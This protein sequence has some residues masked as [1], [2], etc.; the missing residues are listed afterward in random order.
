MY[1]GNDVIVI[2]NNIND[3]SIKA[4]NATIMIN[5]E[6]E[7]ISVGKNCSFIDVV[8]KVGKNSQLI[9][10]DWCK[11]KGE[12]IVGDDSILSIG[13]NTLFNDSR[14][15]VRCEEGKTISIGDNCLFSNTAIYNS[16]YHAIYSGAT[17][18]RINQ[19]EDVVIES[20]V[21][22]ALNSVILKGGGVPAGCVVGAGAIV[23]KKFSVN[24][25]ILAGNP[26]QIVQENILWSDDRANIHPD[27]KNK[28][29][30]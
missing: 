10:G 9:V 20:N 7:L 12:V 30:G 28:L 11:I 14:S 17:G 8:L 3:N 16:D 1:Y 4:S 5:E 23:N 24:N 19:A 25:C 22:C 26:A 27:F 15:V 29:I 6:A 13:N 18:L 2:K 21:W